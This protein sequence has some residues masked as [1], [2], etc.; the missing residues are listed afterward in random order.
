MKQDTIHNPTPKTTFIQRIVLMLCAIFFFLSVLEIGLR[1]AGLIM[2]SAW[3]KRNNDS[4]RKRG[5]YRI[6]CLGE[7]T[8]A[9]KAEAYP[10]LLE[11]A[12]SSLVPE[13]TFSVINCGIPS[14]NSTRLLSQL[15]KDLDKYDPDMVIAMMGI[16]DGEDYVFFEAQNIPA[17]KRFLSS[18]KVYRLMKLLG[19]HGMSKMREYGF[20]GLTVSGPAPGR[21]T[22]FIK[23]DLNYPEFGKFIGKPSAAVI[24]REC[25][26]AKNDFERGRYDQAEQRYKK[27]IELAP[28]N[29]EAYVT[30]ALFY[31]KQD[32]FPQAA[33]LL[34]KAIALAPHKAKAY[35]FLGWCYEEMREYD[36]ARLM[37]LKAAEVEP[38]NPEAYIGLGYVCERQGSYTEAEPLFKKALGLNHAYD[39]RCYKFLS[40]LYRQRGD[41]ARAEEYSLLLEKPNRYNPLTIANYQKL[42]SI[43]V[44]ARGKKLVC[45]SYPLESI[46]LLQKVF[47]G[48]PD[49]VL[50]DNGQIFKD[51]VAE[52]GYDHYFIDMFAGNFGHCTKKGNSLLAN[53]VAEAIV[54]AMGQAAGSP[55]VNDR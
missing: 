26:R 41:K 19:R 3:E 50:V 12:L 37:F 32:K 27:I 21:W 43:V 51:A 53:N 39:H 4:L 22:V 55:S 13:K 16:N 44:D 28:D 54:K 46:G 2:V 23:N 33:L 14:V 17:L 49:V 5:A 35:I 52:H 18:F 9:G 1:L 48:Q 47:G 45:M 42:K 15:N 25:L 36:Q 40:G 8:T 20:S 31:N 6:L 30:Y 11:A 38:R 29:D 7:S 34:Q 10:A 24:Q